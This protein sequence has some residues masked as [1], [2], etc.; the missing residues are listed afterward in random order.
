MT[1]M[2]TASGGFGGYEQDL[3][4]YL[5]R[6]SF[7]GGLIGLYKSLSWENACVIDAVVPHGR[8][9][10]SRGLVDLR[11]DPSFTSAGSP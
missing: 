1:G 4:E 5:G 6:C 9:R 8:K 10:H 7:V 11:A 3:G 2:V